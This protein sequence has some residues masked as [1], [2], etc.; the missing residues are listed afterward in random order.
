VHDRRCRRGDH[1]D[2]YVTN[3]VDDCLDKHDDEYFHD[4]HDNT[5]AKG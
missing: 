3:L 4:H 1:D 5:A 2:I